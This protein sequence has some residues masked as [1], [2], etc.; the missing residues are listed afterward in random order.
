MSVKIQKLV[1]IPGVRA[2]CELISLGLSVDLSQ[3]ALYDDLMPRVVSYY[4]RKAIGVSPFKCFRKKVFK[5]DYETKMKE[6]LLK[7]YEPQ[8]AKRR[9][10]MSLNRLNQ[11]F[12]VK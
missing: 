11:V 6:I 5:G 10:F 9:V 3:P 7:E 2:Q 4:I 1:A 12:S 8:E